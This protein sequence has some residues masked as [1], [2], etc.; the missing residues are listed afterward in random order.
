[1]YKNP[2]KDGNNHCNKSLLTDFKEK[3][4]QAI[5]RIK[6]EIDECCESESQT[7]LE[8]VH[9]ERC[10]D[11]LE[12]EVHAEFLNLHRFLYEEESTD[13]QR[14]KKERE[15]RV[16][17][18]KERER[19]I[20]MQGKDLEKAIE[21]LN[22]KLAEEDS[23]S[24]LKEIQDLLKR[25]NVAFISPPKVDV[26]IRSGHFVGPIQ[27]RIWKHMKKCIYPNITEVTFDPET[28][29][30]LLTL[31]PSCTSVRF[32]EKKVICPSSKEDSP[33]PR[34]FHYY[35]SVMGSESFLTGRHYW[36][37]EVGQ[38]TAW[39]VGVAREDVHRGEM[40]SCGTSS[41]LWTL[42]LKGGLVRAC[43][44]PKPTKIPVSI[45]PVRIGVFLDCEKEEV[46][47][48]NAVTMT[49]LYTFFMGMVPVPLMPF[50]NPCDSDDGRNLDPLNLFMPS[51]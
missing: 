38:K 16:K 28:A 9:V 46:A 22:S 18:L 40:D 33:S 17:M 25:S 1:M 51:L 19:K 20:A 27:Y 12:R 11:T 32:E 4:I 3:L 23:P 13:L 42:S 29:H 47:F 35:Y 6:H 5:K 15:K 37:V 44:E 14:L 34:R 41:G 2:I 7:Y 36:E 31:S 24:L 30:P 50:Y 45:R 21:T 48:Y 26:G 49:P 39:R 8:S 10:F 43:T